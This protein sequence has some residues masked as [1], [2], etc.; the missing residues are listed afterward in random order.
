MSAEAAVRLGQDPRTRWVSLDGF[1]VNTGTTRN[2]AVN[3]ANLQSTYV[4]AIGADRVWNEAPNYY[5]GQNIGVAVVDSGVNPQQDFY[6]TMGVNHLIYAVQF[7]GGYNQ[8]VYDGYGHGTHVAGIIANTGFRSNST[9]M[10]VAPNANII[11]V[12]VSDDT[13]AATASN[14]VSGLQWINDHASQ[15]N[16]R[17]VNV[18]L[19]TSTPTDYNVDPIDAAVEVLWFNRVVVVVSAGNNG[20]TGALYSPA[21]DPFVITVGATDD[22]GTAGIS[23][24]HN[25]FFLGLRNRKRCSQARPGSSGH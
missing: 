6:T 22:L 5:Q 20:T 18:S 3:T 14:V 16:I 7:N 1:M 4:K 24:R 17:V 23:G 11:N 19:N 25:R 15:Y 9:Y 21:N 12:K 8:S 2:G 10:G 13:G